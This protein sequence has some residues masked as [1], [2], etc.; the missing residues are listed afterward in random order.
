MLYLDV[1]ASPVELHLDVFVALDVDTEHGQRRR[2]QQALN[3]VEVLIEKAAMHGFDPNEL[4]GIQYTGCRA[5]RL[6]QGDP[7]AGSGSG[8]GRS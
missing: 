8:A 6:S 5:R 4:G 3:R 1:D 7:S 2:R